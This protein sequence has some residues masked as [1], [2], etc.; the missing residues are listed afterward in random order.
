MFKKIYLIV[1]SLFVTL[2][3]VMTPLAANAQTFKD[4]SKSTTFK[5]EIE[6]LSALRVTSGYGDKTYRPNSPVRRDHMILFIYRS[7]GSPAYSP[8]KT[9]P[10]TDIKP[11]NKYYKEIMWAYKKGIT[12]GYKMKNGSKQFR[13]SVKVRRDHMAAFLM[14]ASGDKKPSVKGK[15]FKDISKKYAYASEIQWMKNTGISTG[16]GDGRYMPKSNTTRGHM[17]AF[18]SRWIDHSVYPNIAT[19]KQQR[20]WTASLPSACQKIEIRDFS[21]KNPN[22]KGT[23]FSASVKYDGNGVMYYTLKIDGNMKAS[24]PAAKALMKHECGHVLMGIYSDN[25][26]RSNFQDTLSKGWPSSNKNRVENAADCIAD[27]LG[28]VRQT[29]NYKVGYGTVCN[30]AQKN[31]AKTFVN[32]GKT[33]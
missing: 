7:M 25:K 13:P 6:R 30:S 24:D 16:T 17:A 11:N 3:M 5:S 33:L 32:F 8:P 19:A 10:F 1:A 23:S 28:A 20:D 15:P 14:R 18:M 12:T 26:G 29:K 2:G 22:K 27:Q 21:I 31:V 4:V 9:S